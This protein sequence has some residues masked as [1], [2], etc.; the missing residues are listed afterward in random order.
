MSSLYLQVTLRHTKIDSEKTTP[1]FEL[2][3]RR[4]QLALESFRA[5]TIKNLHVNADP[6]P[7]R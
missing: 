4:D 2:T 5:A 3:E 6:K 1:A 7:P